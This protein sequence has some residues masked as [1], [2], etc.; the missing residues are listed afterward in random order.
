MLLYP[1]LCR[2]A[3][4]ALGFID[5]GSAG[6]YLKVDLSVQT[7]KD[8][9]SVEGTYAALYPLVIILL[10]LYAFG[11][12]LGIGC[13]MQ[14]KRRRLGR[15]WGKRLSRAYVQF[16]SVFGFLFSEYRFLYWELTESIRKFLIG[17]LERFVAVYHA[18]FILSSAVAIPIVLGLGTGMSSSVQVR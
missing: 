1:S 17:E 8:D 5:L 14:H 2:K 13:V 16:E 9:G 10:L 6:E 18:C 3:V 11:I 15:Q 12:P 4:Q 7:R